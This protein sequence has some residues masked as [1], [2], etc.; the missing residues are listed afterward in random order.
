MRICKKCGNE[1]IDDEIKYCSRCGSDL[2]NKENV[3]EKSISDQIEEDSKSVEDG[4]F[5]V[6][7]KQ[8]SRKICTLLQIT[9]GFTGASFF[10]LGF[11]GRGII[12][13]C[14]NI[15]FVLAAGLLKTPFWLFGILF[16]NFA[17]GIGWMFKR[18][19]IDSKGED[20]K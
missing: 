15:A 13:I 20:L 7:F 1:E 11:W 12:W 18:D 6:S 14:V 17:L 10:Y 9:I 19:L 2:S 3:L 8:K 4:S 16:V 5:Y